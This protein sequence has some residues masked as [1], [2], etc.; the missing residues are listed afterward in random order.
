MNWNSLLLEINA[1]VC[2]VI[3]IRLILFRRQK[4]DMPYNFGYSVFSYAMIVTNGTIVIRVLTGEYAHADWS[5]V[6]N[7]IFIC[8]SLLFS[9]GSIKK[10]FHKERPTN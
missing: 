1:V 3:V 8:I 10:L 5:T 6:L 7:N 9:G 2:S 4:F